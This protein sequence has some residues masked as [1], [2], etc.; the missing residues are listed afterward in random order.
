MPISMIVGLLI[1]YSKNVLSLSIGI[2]GGLARELASFW[3]LLCVNN[4]F[5]GRIIF[6]SRIIAVFGLVTQYHESWLYIYIY[7]L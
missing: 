1:L 2:Y 6:V 7:I 4:S 5:S 3:A